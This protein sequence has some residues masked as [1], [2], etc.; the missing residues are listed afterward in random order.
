MQ[1]RKV[2]HHLLIAITIVHSSP[3]IKSKEA[4]DTFQREKEDT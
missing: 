2:L 1:E 4:R 3:I